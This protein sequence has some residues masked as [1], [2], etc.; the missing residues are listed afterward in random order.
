MVKHHS[1]FRHIFGDTPKREFWFSDIPKPFT[2][3]GS[4]YAAANHK[5]VAYAKAGAGG[6]VHLFDLEDTGRKGKIP[7]INTHKGKVTD[8]DFNPFVPEMI[9]TAGEDCHVHVVAFPKGGLKEDIKKPVVD[10]TGHQKKVI[11]VAFNPVANNILASVSYDHV[12]KVWDISTGECLRTWEGTEDVVYSM[13]WSPCGGEIAVTTKT[14]ELIVFDPRAPESARKTTSFKSTKMSKVFWC[15][16]EK[17]NFVGAVGV[18]SRGKRCLKLWDC[19]ELG[20]PIHTWEIDNASSVL[21]PYYDEDLSILYLFGKGDGSILFVEISDQKG[22]QAV[23]LGVHRETDPQKGGCFIGKRG[24]R[25]MRCEVQRFMKLTQNAIIPIPMVVPRK[26]DLFQGDL[27]P[28]TYLGKTEL[29]AG[30]WNDGKNGERQYC[31]MDPTKQ[32][33]DD[34]VEFKAKLSYKDLE[35]KCA[36]L[37]KRVDYLEGKCQEAGIK[38][39]E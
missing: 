35:A 23:L 31:S 16:T 5:Y 14:K 8:I 28:D 4:S 18:T 7:M 32:T 25:V 9:A 30:D 1:K 15:R 34:G 10:L 12:L 36:E 26:S 37:Q 39:E 24:C 21:I 13:E 11:Y 3:G 38:V 20:E 27:Y 33:S 22:K 2:S 19:K 6:P 17:V 29:E